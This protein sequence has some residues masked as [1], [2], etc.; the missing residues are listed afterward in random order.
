MFTDCGAAAGPV[1]PRDC[2]WHGP[3][4][5]R[6]P[7]LA[8]LLKSIPGGRFHPQKAAARPYRQLILQSY[9]SSVSATSIP[10]FLKLRR[11]HRRGGLGH[12]AGRV[13]H[14]RKCDHVADAVR[15]HH[16]HHHAV[17]AVCQARVGG[18]PYLNASSRNPN[19][20]LARSGVKAQ[21]LEHLGTAY[22]PDGY[23]RSRCPS[24]RR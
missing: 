17:K 19:W 2:G 12:Q 5:P 6:A 11:V 21:H 24:P 7:A 13:L 10:S 18:T 3:V 16:Q 4:A 8:A 1:G 9:S 14:L 23:G 20:S 22:R 15:A